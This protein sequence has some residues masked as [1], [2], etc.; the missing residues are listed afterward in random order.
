MTGFNVS[1]H[2]L[3]Q[4]VGH[5]TGHSTLALFFLAFFLPP[6][7]KAAVPDNIDIAKMKKNI[8]F[9]LYNLRFKNEVNRKYSD[10]RLRRMPAVSYYGG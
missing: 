7:A 5:A 9:I 10:G 2:Y 6:A 3:Q 4:V 8:F 1:K